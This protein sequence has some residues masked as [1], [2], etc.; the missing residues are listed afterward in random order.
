LFSKGD[1]K[2]FPVL[3]VFLYKFR[4]DF[5]NNLGTTNIKPQ[6]VAYT[7]ASGNFQVWDVFDVGT[8]NE[9]IIREYLI[10][11]ISSSHR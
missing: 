4:R 2:G 5:H 11:N 3:L 6:G 1:T 10:Y 7:N 9:F 8:N